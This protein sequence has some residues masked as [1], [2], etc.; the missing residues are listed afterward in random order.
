MGIVSIKKIQEALVDFCQYQ[1][2]YV[3]TER[4]VRKQLES[5]FAAADYTRKVSLITHEIS[6][7]AIEL[8]GED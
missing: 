8:D 4:E 3:A 1:T 7:Y 5:A 2:G 6:S